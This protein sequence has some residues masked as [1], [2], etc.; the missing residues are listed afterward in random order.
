MTR[1]LFLVVSALVL[2][3][4]L[5]AQQQPGYSQRL[6]CIKVLPGKSAEYRQFVADT[7]VKL[8]QATI[9][10]GEA[11]TWTLLRAV[12][13][14]GSEARCDYMSS[15]VY[16]GPPAEPQGRPGLEKA[17]QRAG[18][19][20]NAADYIARRDFLSRLVSTEI[21]NMRIREGQP[22]KGN[23]VFLN[24]MKV[25]NAAEYIKFENEVWRPLAAQWIK[26]GAQS[27]WVFATAVL[28]GG[29]DLKYAAYSADIYPSWKV[30]F[31]TRTTVETFKK[32]HPSKD[33]QQTMAPLGKLRDLARRELLVIE[34]R[35]SKK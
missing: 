29:T 32:A 31:Q 5:H 6:A 21:W 12:T 28:P 15:T 11:A 33:Y 30:T 26:E 2:P 17:L 7:T 14:A 22:Q 18:V 25:H 13:P 24:Y 8:M 4:G 27:G 34:E 1:V 10:A 20:M 9:N 19:K 23:Y 3:G 16:E 35:I